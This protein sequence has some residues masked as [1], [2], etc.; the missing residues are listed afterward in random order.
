MRLL[1]WAALRRDREH[2]YLHSYF[3]FTVNKKV[4]SHFLHSLQVLTKSD[5]GHKRGKSSQV[6]TE[7]VCE[8]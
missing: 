5:K 6:E 8:L 4:E 1:P 2:V 7:V 3:F